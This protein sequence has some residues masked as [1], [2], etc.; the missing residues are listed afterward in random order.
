MKHN[1]YLQ[2]LMANLTTWPLILRPNLVFFRLCNSKNGETKWSSSTY[3]FN[4]YINST[5]LGWSSKFIWIVRL[6]VALFLPDNNGFKFSALHSSF[7]FPYQKKKERKQ[8]NKNYQYHHSKILRFRI[9][10]STNRIRQ[11]PN[12]PPTAADIQSFE[13]T[14]NMYQDRQ[15]PVPLNQ[16]QQI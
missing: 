11:L 14:W 16:P 13:Y 3:I 2:S 10:P 9:T 5:L 1:L 12:T 4:W 6:F 7:P 15:Y 8:K